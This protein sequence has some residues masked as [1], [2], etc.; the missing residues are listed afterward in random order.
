MLPNFEK[1]GF[2]VGFAE[3]RDVRVPLNIEIIVYFRKRNFEV[4]DIQRARRTGLYWG[5]IEREP[6]MFFF[7]VDFRPGV[8][9]LSLDNQ[10]I[11][12]SVPFAAMESV[13]DGGLVS[14]VLQSKRQYRGK[15][16]AVAL[17]RAIEK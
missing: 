9:V 7:I 17:F 8:R 11:R 3:I 14:E 16:F 13:H 4:F 15:V 12:Q 1:Q 5:G 2:L 6:R 10:G